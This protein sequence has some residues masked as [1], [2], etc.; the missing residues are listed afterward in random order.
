MRAARRWLVIS[1]VLGKQLQSCEC[2]QLNVVERKAMGRRRRGGDGGVGTVTRQERRV[3]VLV[4]LLRQRD[5]VPGSEVQCKPQLLCAHYLSRP[6]LERFIPIN[7]DELHQKQAK[8]SSLLMSYVEVLC[9]E[10]REHRRVLS[11]FL[12]GTSLVKC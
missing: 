7:H 10:T 1:I 5:S 3:E 12:S 9:I 4:L 6:R 2:L 11:Q 8:R